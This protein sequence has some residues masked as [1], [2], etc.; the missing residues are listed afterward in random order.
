MRCPVGGSLERLKVSVPMGGL[1]LPVSRGG[2]K[3]DRTSTRR[4]CRSASAG[5][6]LGFARVR[7]GSNTNMSSESIKGVFMGVFRRLRVITVA[8]ALL[9]LLGFAFAAPVE[10]GRAHV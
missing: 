10:I 4:D 6:P 7:S 5:S 3:A 1:P 8:L 9:G 2:S